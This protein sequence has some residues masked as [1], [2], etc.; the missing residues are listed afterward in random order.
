M[1]KS[2]S[3]NYF[4]NVGYQLLALMTP[5]ITTPY[6]ARVLGADGVGTYSYTMSLTTYFVLF[7]SLGAGE[8]GTRAV[9]YCQTDV[10]RRSRI[11]FEVWA[12]RVVLTA[13]SLCMYAAF[14]LHDGGWSKLYLVQSL[15]VLAVAADVTWFF[16]GLEDFGRIV[17][18]N[19]LMRIIQVGLVFLCVRQAEDLVVYAALVGGVTLASGFLLWGYLPRRLVWVSWR[20]WRPFRDFGTVVQLFLPQAAISIYVVLDKTMLGMLGGSMT[21]SGWYSQ[22]DKMVHLSITVLT[23]MGTVMAPRIAAAFAAGEEQAVRTGIMRSYRL[24]WFLGLP[25]MFGWM[26]IAG[27]VTPWFLGT[28]YEG[29]PLLLWLM[30]GLVVL[31]GLSNVTGVQYLVPTGGQNLLTLTVTVGA[32]VNFGLNSWLIPVW[33]AKGAALATLISETV[34]TG[35]QLFVVR[36]IFS[37]GAIWQSSVVYWQSSLIMFFLTVGLGYYLPATMYSTACMIFIGAGIYGTIL[38]NRGEH[39]SKRIVISVRRRLCR[40]WRLFRSFSSLP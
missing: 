23:A 9:A 37:I 12:L 38:F 4:Y 24:V 18:R 10:H 32:L 28:G 30:A 6:L 39:F 29:V 15:H 26:A 21:E 34:V 35:T 8:Y 40:K 17:F 22:A 19:S 13:V 3:R 31:I 25:M 36:N 7:A 16:Q 1:S 27:N 33:G 11:F 5:L 14:F 20:E 2:V